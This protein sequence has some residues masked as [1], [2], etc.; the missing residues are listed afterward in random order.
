[1]K[2]SAPC[3]FDRTEFEMIVQNWLSDATNYRAHSRAHF[4][5]IREFIQYVELPADKSYINFKLG[6]SIFCF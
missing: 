1:M 3:D 6:L 2:R 5:Q 4:R